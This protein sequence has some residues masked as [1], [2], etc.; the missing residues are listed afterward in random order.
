[1]SIGRIWGPTML[2]DQIIFNGWFFNPTIEGP[3]YEGMKVLL[4]LAAYTNIGV[5]GKPL[6][7]IWMS[8]FIAEI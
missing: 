6:G 1:M 3:G 2:F 4:T 5:Y 7:K 8:A